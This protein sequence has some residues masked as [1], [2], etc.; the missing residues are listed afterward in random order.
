MSIAE[1]GSSSGSWILGGILTEGIYICMNR[2]GRLHKEQLW[3]VLRV[4]IPDFTTQE[5]LRASVEVQ[6]IEIYTAPRCWCIVRPTA[7]IEHWGHE[8]V[9]SSMI[10]GH[11]ILNTQIELTPGLHRSTGAIP[12]KKFYRNTTIVVES[13]FHPP[14]M[15]ESGLRELL[16]STYEGCAGSLY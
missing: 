7:M 12:I 8:S 9:I 3:S 10:N 13:G 6:E 16:S 14:C 11:W 1:V 15:M 5:R 2:R 4:E